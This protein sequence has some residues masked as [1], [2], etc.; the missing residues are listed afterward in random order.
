MAEESAGTPKGVQRD[1]I[2]TRLPQVFLPRANLFYRAFLL[3]IPFG[4][5]V[6]GYTWYRLCRSPDITEVRMPIG[7]PVMFSH[8]HHVGDLK[9]DCRYCHTSAEKSSFAGVP[10]TQICMSCHS[11]LFT[12]SPLLEPVRESAAAGRPIAW[13]R[14]HNLPDYVYFNHSIHV[15]KGVGCTTCHGAVNEMPLMMK[16]QTLFMEWCLQCHRDPA[17]TQRPDSEIYSVSWEPGPKQGETGAALALKHHL[18]SEHLTNCSVC[19][20]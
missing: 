15:N 5:L 10:S 12:D 9:I 18:D 3:A 19:H 16:T 8:R 14:V 1:A 13:N 11:Q 20:R 17:R 4:A 2:S 6:G 7:Q